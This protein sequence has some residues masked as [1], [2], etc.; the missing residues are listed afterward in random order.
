MTTFNSLEYTR[1]L[2]RAAAHAAT[3]SSK[4]AYET[5]QRKNKAVLLEKIYE[6]AVE[7]SM[8]EAQKKQNIDYLLKASV[9]QALNI[10][11]NKDPVY[12]DTETT[13]INGEVVEIAIV[14]FDGTPLLN[15]L[16]NPLCPIPETATAIHGITDL[17][18]KD[19]PT[20]DAIFPRIQNILRN[21]VLI[22]YNLQYDLNVLTRKNKLSSIPTMRCGMHTYAR[23]YQEP[24]LYDFK[25][26][27]LSAALEQ[28]GIAP[29][30]P[31]HRAYTD[32]ESTRL[33]MHQ[34][35]KWDGF[36]DFI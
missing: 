36:E 26:Q 10:D 17:D 23:F 18:V 35:A 8:Q 19:A 33:L 1:E 32:A 30:R 22:G 6:D 34:I 5:Q 2:A 7:K 4:D 29:L 27:K 16:V 24:G 11:L 31:Q 28:Q 12:L 20:L 21:R 14:D 15:T 25:W 3:T 13:G 9:V